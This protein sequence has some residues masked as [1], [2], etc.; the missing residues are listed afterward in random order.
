MAVVRK[1]ESTP[2]STDHA[3]WIFFRQESGSAWRQP[4]SRVDAIGRF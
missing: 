1:G 4:K 3:K 2:W